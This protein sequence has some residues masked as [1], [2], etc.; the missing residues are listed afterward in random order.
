[1]VIEQMIWHGASEELGHELPEPVNCV[2]TD[3]PYG[4]DHQSRQATTPEGKRWATK[5]KNDKDLSEAIALFQDAMKPILPKLADHADL[6]IFTR[7]DIVDAWMDAVRDLQDIKYK[8]LLVWEKGSPGMGDID[9]NWG[10]GHELILYC[11]RGRREVPY[12]RSA[13]IHVDQVRA[14]K[15]IHPNEKPVALI[16]E[17]IK[18]STDRGDLIVDPFSGSGSTAVAAQRTGRSCIGIELDRTHVQRSRARLGS[19]SFDFD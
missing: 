12:R 4:V 6:Y 5:I 1:M 13:V 7:W 16:E 3:P 18:M 8:M 10:C 11:K 19:L 14:S 15:M 17:L 2:I 9:S